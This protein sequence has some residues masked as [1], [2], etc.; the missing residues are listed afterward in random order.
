MMNKYVVTMV[1]Q[2][3][4]KEKLTIEAEGLKDAQDKAIE[5]ANNG[6]LRGKGWVVFNVRQ[7]K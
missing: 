4:E 7:K 5:D 3:G 6:W 1:N 2:D